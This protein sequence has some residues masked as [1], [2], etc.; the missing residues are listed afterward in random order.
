MAPCLRL[1]WMSCFILQSRVIELTR[2]SHEVQASVHQVHIELH[3][4]AS[5]WCET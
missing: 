5:S 3:L 1:R 4:L 2:G